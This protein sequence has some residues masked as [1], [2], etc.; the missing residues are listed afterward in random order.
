[1]KTAI[2]SITSGATSGVL[3]II[4]KNNMSHTYLGIDQNDQI[5]MQLSYTEEQEGLIKEMY[6]IMEEMRKL[7][8]AFNAV[9]TPVIERQRAES[10]LSFKKMDEEFEQRK[11]AR[12]EKKVH[13][14]NIEEQ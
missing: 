2:I 1:M 3:G 13:D 7:V 12:L 6:T 8:D 14:K 11:K 10:E 9:M 4:R 5:L